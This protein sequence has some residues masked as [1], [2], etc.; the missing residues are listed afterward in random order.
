[1]R[2]VYLTLRCE[3]DP[4]GVVRPVEFLWEDGRRFPV[5]RV[6]DVRRAVSLKT[7]GRGIRYTVR[8]LDREV[9]LY[10]DGDRWYLEAP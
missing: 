5:D 4:E 1:M 3:F 10:R 6:L 9:C 7:G 2:K 8:V